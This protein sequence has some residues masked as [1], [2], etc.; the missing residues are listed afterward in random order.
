MTDTGILQLPWHRGLDETLA[1]SHGQSL[2]GGDRRTFFIHVPNS[3]KPRSHFWFTALRQVEQRKIPAIQNYHVDLAGTLTDWAGP[4]DTGYVFIIRGKDVP[5]SKLRR[6]MDSVARQK[7]EGFGMIFID[8]GSTN[9][10]PEYLSEVLLPTWGERARAL[11]N[12]LPL[13]SAENNTI[14]IR[15]I[16]SNPESVIVT[17]DMDDALIGDR[18][19]ECLRECYRT[20]ADLT[21]GSM[22]R[23]DKWCEYPAT[24]EDPR[25]ARGGNVWQHLR[26]FRKYLFDA[27][28]ESYFKID[29][30]WI[31]SAEDWAFMI[32]MAEMAEH[33]VYI[34]RKL[35]FY[36]PTGKKDHVAR[37]QRENL[38]GQIVGKGPLNMEWTG[39]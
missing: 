28:P 9:Q 36:E 37:M 30:E 2:R 20:G 21:V 25:K 5:I 8:A 26:S 15:E 7:D 12:T 23:T 32:P 31:P 3:I 18:V 1:Q 35:Y 6:C 39:S 11:F 16:C 33:P 38:I 19:I 4:L 24:F 14:A 29:G 22:L 10:I 13:T 34:E 17:L 27:I